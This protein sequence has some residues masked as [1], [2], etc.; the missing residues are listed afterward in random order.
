MSLCGIWGLPW[1]IKCIPQLVLVCL[2]YPDLEYQLWMHLLCIWTRIQHEY[3]LRKKKKKKKSLLYVTQEYIYNEN[4]FMGCHQFLSRIM[5]L[6]RNNGTR[7]KRIA[8]TFRVNNHPVNK[9]V[10]FTERK[11]IYIHFQ[12]NH[13]HIFFLFFFSAHVKVFLSGSI[14]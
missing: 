4:C 9:P 6:H 1:V 8:E 5:A 11:K 2:W 12:R 3:S 13:P 10:H 14:F 7:R